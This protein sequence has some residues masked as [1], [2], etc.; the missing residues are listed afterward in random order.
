MTID[1]N[2]DP[3]PELRR[4]LGGIAAAVVEV[5]YDRVKP[6]MSFPEFA[7]RAIDRLSY[8]EVRDLA[9]PLVDAVAAVLTQPE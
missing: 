3:R 4:N 1:L 9:A 8:S 7:Q 5:I 6:P 2:A